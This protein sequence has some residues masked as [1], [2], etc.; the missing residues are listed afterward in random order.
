MIGILLR[1]GTEKHDRLGLLRTEQREFGYLQEVEQEVKAAVEK[2]RAKE[3]TLSDE[4][5]E[6]FHL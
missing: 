2:V 4:E 3:R 5:I 1:N 6:A